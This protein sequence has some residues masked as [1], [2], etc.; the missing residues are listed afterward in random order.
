MK[1]F[2]IKV[3]E[4]MSFFSEMKVSIKIISLLF[5][6]FSGVV[7][8]GYLVF[9]QLKIFR[10][11]AFII[12]N[13]GIVRGSIQR[14]TKNEL[15]DIHADDLII[16]LDSLIKEVKL[17]SK[18]NV[19]SS[20][21]KKHQQLDSRINFL[22]DEWASL[23]TLYYKHRENNIYASE[24]LNKSELN[25]LTAIDT[26]FIAQE[27]NEQKLEKYKELIIYIMLV[28]AF[29]IFIIVWLVYKIVHKNL[30]IDAITDPMTKLYNRNHF[31]KILHKQELFSERYNSCFSLIL[32]DVDYFKKVNDDFG[33]QIGDKVL[34]LLA[35]ILEDNSRE[36][37][38]VFRLGGEEFAIILPQSN[39]EQA[40]MMAEKHRKLIAETDF[41]IGRILTVSMGVSQFV[42]NENSEDFFKRTDIA[43]YEAKSSGRNKTVSSNNN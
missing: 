34:I 30:E 39:L 35:K 6:L 20:L 24:I 9:D 8:G 2:F 19:I 4:I 10:D 42:V 22:E 29:F 33:H 18:V 43:L 23:K 28:I 12:N 15:N 31:N 21:N 25:W 3:R 32:C 27:L 5:F 11:D 41:D 16:Q 38:V 14:I 7:I 13:L 26:V 36:I 40:I 1:S 17:R 37:D